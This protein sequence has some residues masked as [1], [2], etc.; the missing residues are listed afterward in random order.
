M[1][2]CLISRCFTLLQCQ[3]IMKFLLLLCFYFFGVGASYAEIRSAAEI[4]MTESV[5]SSTQMA[6]SSTQAADARALDAKPDVQV[7][8]S[9]ALSVKTMPR[10]RKNTQYFYRNIWEPTYHILRLNYCMFDGKECGMAVASRYCRMLGYDGADKEIVANNVGLTHVLASKAKC[11]GWQCNGF[12]LIRCIG[13][14]NHQ[15]AKPY[16]YREKR[17]VY[18]RLDSYRIAWCY[19]DGKECGQRAAYSFCRRMG[20]LQA[21]HYKKE[22]EIAATKEL[23]N[24]KLC[25]GKDCSGFQYITCYR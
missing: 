13:K 9:G 18:P 11:Q 21:K 8:D 15:P 22:T 3:Q 7:A 4:I 2:M 16:Y 1:T 10:S 6:N 17:F 12:K 5:I 14:I 24:Q 20:Y 19:K 25:F 23:G